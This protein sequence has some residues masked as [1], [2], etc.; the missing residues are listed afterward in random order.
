M[1]QY[2]CPTSHPLRFRHL[3][4]KQQLAPKVLAAINATLAQQGL[5]LKT[6]TVVDTTI[7]AAP[8][9]TK[10]AEGER[11]LEMH[12]TKKDNQGHFSMKA[13]IG[14]DGA[15]ATAVYAGIT[16]SWGPKRACSPVN[17]RIGGAKSL[18][19]PTDVGRLAQRRHNGGRFC[20]LSLRITTHLLNGSPCLNSFISEKSH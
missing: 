2:A 13:H 20:R 15:Q 4:E 3:L 8:S 16:T 17:S 7:V 6:G 1:A 9:S 11:D 19:P 14:V 12:Q 10:N 18:P 5:M